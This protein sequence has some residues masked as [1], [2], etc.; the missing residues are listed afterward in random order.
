[1]DGKP[2]GLVSAAKS[3]MS[4][5]TISTSLW[6]DRLALSSQSVYKLD[7]FGVVSFPRR[8]QVSSCLQQARLVV[9]VIAWARGV[10]VDL[11]Y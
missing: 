7:V 9:G 6:R 11:S 8:L 1:M 5:V 4:T 10:Y 2:H 3:V